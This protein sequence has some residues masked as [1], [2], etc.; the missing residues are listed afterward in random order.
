M[1]I[2][3]QNCIST[4]QKIKIARVNHKFYIYFNPTW[5]LQET[6]FNRVLMQLLFSASSNCLWSKDLMLSFFHNLY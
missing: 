4:S 5:I 3:W 6:L 1:H 2:L